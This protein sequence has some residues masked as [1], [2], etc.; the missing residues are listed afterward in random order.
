[1]RGNIFLGRFVGITVFVHWT[2]ALLLL[3]VAVADWRD[4]ADWLGIADSVLFMLAVFACVTLHEFGHALAARRYGIR[5]LDIILLPIGGVARLEAMPEKPWQEIVVAVAGPMVNVVIAAIIVLALRL[6][7]GFWAWQYPPE[8]LYQSFV[9]R[10]CL[11][12]V[13]LVVFNAIPAFPMDGG[14]V[15]RASL[16]FFMRRVIATRIAALIGQ[17]LAIGFILYGFTSG[18]YTLIITGV[19]IFWAASSEARMVAEREDLKNFNVALATR[20]N[21]TLLHTHQTIQQAIDQLLSGTEQDFVVTENEQVVGVL[22]RQSLIRA[23]ADNYDKQASIAPLITRNIPILI[24]EYPL[25]QAYNVMRDN[26]FSLLPVIK[27]GTLIGVIDTENIA[28]LIHLI[29]EPNK[30]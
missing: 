24:P 1:M 23:L 22:Y 6:F 17:I 8:M 10:L 11:S 12:N 3:Y 26:N 20:S 4:G 27:D 30:Q 29:V 18:V 5:T 25:H 21:Y 15:L 16:S 28:E 2:F 14:R 19:F 7:D 9:L 13:I